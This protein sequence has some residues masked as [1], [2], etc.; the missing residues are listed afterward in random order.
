MEDATFGPDSATPLAGNAERFGFVDGSADGRDFSSQPF[1]APWDE[2]EPD[3][4][5]AVSDCVR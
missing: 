2:G 5:D 1:V 4:S 3:D